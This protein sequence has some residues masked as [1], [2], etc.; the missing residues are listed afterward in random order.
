M[1][2]PVRGAAFTNEV[3]EALR[4]LIG[5]AATLSWVPALLYFGADIYDKY[6]N[7]KTEYKPDSVRGTEQAIFQGLASIALPLLAVR[8]GQNLFSLFGVLTK[9]N[10][11]I[12]TKEHINDLAQRFVANGK[13]H[14][15][16]NDDKACIRDFMSVVSNNMDLSD[17]KRIKH[18]YSKNKKNIHN[19][20]ESTVKELIELRKKL[21]SPSE[22]FKE[23]PLYYN[24]RQSLKKGETKNVAVKSALTKQLQT[25]ALKGKLVK[26]LGGFIALGLAIN[27]IDKFVENVLL[28]KYISPRLEKK[29][30]K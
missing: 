21:L 30:T 22:E 27:P 16:H 25:K 2:W 12:N 19:Y 7:D 14:A 15:H 23:T 18:V 29:R 10:I 9:D 1:N 5:G 28:G 4:P 26:T 3:G 8:T 13:M 20:A 24:Y 11:S 17:K 6:K